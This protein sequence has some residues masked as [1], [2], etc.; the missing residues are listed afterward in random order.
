MEGKPEMAS[1]QA[2]AL[3]RAQAIARLREAA[4]KLS[5]LLGIEMPQI[6]SKASQDP[7]IARIALVETVADFIEAASSQSVQREQDARI[8]QAEVARLTKALASAQKPKKPA[9]GA[10]A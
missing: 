9:G 7:E 10:Q 1:P 2:I 4:G 6:A 8:Q 5:E 3:R